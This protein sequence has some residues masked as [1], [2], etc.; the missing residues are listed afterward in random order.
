M[1]EESVVGLFYVRRQFLLAFSVTGLVKIERTLVAHKTIFNAY[2]GNDSGFGH[3]ISD[4][5]FDIRKMNMDA[6]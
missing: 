6:F 5:P 2:F 1:S 3:R 4:R